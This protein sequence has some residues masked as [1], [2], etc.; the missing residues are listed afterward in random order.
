MG[1][2]FART[3]SDERVVTR[4]LSGF[5]RAPKII[6]TL[7]FIVSVLMIAILAVESQADVTGANTSIP[8][9]PPPP[10][11]LQWK[12]CPQDGSLSCTSLFVPLN[13]SKP[14]GRQISIALLKV[15]AKKR[16]K[17]IGSMLVNPGGPGASGVDF[18]A[19]AQ[20]LF[21]SRITDRFDIIGFDPRGTARSA[22]V[23]CVSDQQFEVFVGTDP[24][25]DNEAERAEI[26]SV[27]KGFA[28][29]CAKQVG[30]DA[31]PF[32]G[33]FDVARDM[34]QIRRALNEET[35]SM[36][37]FSYG[38]LL[39]ATYADLFPSRV[40]SFVLD[41]A[42]DAEAT[43]DDRAREQTRGFESVL[44]AYSANCPQRRTCVGAL[45]EDPLATI[46]SLLQQVE[47]VPIPVR[48]RQVGPG[49]A[50]LGLVRALY[51]K[52]RGW[53]LLDGALIAAGNGSGERWLA[54]ADDYT[55]RRANGTFDGLLESNSVINC[56]DNAGS[57][58]LAHYDQLAVEL[59][60]ISPRFGAAIAY[61][62]LPCAYWAVPAAATKWTTRAAGSK[63]ILVVGTT[64]DPA[65]P[66][67]WAQRMAKEL[68]N[69]VL[70]TNVGDSH[71]AYFSGGKC[72]RSAIEDY[73]VDGVVPKTGTR[74]A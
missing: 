54:L 9:V 7:A 69:G 34:E 21:G 25:P 61:G 60:K 28:D 59:D 24:S 65:T 39:G 15:S 33:T 35:I 17:R 16:S 36:M 2:V 14:S 48:G 44:R 40:R 62:N 72:V 45:R 20:R 43:G 64:N 46:D 38:T 3:S 18:A 37:G 71:T 10:A 57:T 13:Y 19:R 29:G 42:L 74:C 63:P 52:E 1:T 31:L 56:T 53:P 50:S 4:F 12:P 47:R 51:S 5:A 55:N 49:E 27:S 6:S 68:E 23:N 66:Y 58:D 22:Q 73:L 32:F 30:A 11:S 8:P 67:V 26:R 41:G 70:L